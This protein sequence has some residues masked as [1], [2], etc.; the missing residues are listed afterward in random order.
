M[1]SCDSSSELH[2]ETRQGGV[3][4]RRV[5][6]KK[7]DAVDAPR[8]C[9]EQGEHSSKSEGCQPRASLRSTPELVLLQSASFL[10][11]RWCC[12]LGLRVRQVHQGSCAL[13]GGAP[14]THAAARC[15]GAAHFQLRQRGAAGVAVHGCICQRCPAGVGLRPPG[16]PAGACVRQVCKGASCVLGRGRTAPPALLAK[17][18]RPQYG[19]YCRAENR[20]AVQPSTLPACPPECRAQ[21]P[22]G[23]CA[24]QPPPA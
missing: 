4:Q 19:H 24:A 20:Q 11:M 12:S 15:G 16:S 18:A 5:G 3:G 13:K 22:C 14:G 2:R 23:S 10:L 7:A 21:V 9:G 17:P 1:A 8:S 6:G